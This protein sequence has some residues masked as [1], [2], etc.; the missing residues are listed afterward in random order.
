MIIHQVKL[1]EVAD[2]RAGNPAPQDKSM[3][4]NGKYPFVRTS[5]VGAVKVGELN[6]SRD[7]LNEKG[8][9]K[10]KIFQNTLICKY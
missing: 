1:K 2:V 6:T 7:F 8:I 5:D 3:F 4:S 10:L 9:N